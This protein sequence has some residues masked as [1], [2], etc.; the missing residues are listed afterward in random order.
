MISPSLS[1]NGRIDLIMSIFSDRDEVEVFEYLSENDAQ[2]FV[3]MIDEASVCT[4]LSL[5][6]G[7]C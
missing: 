3:D 5:K 7:S 1:A 2:A 4:I 6:T